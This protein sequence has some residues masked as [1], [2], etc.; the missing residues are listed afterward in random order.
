MH[1]W[2][3]AWEQGIARSVSSALKSCRHTGQSSP[4]REAPGTCTRPSML[5]GGGGAGT[6]AA[7]AAISLAE[8][9][10]DGSVQIW[11]ELELWWGGEIDGSYGRGRDPPHLREPRRPQGSHVRIAFAAGCCIVFISEG[12]T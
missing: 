2:W 6:L 4:E 3:K 12:L 8:E 1:W 5:G 9:T 10:I 7:A 11:V